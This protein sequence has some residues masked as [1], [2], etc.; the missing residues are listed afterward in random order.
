MSNLTM[1]ACYKQSSL[2]NASGGSALF[3]IYLWEIDCHEHYVA[4]WVCLPCS[5]YE[6]D[7]GDVTATQF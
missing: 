4:E 3:E 5:V 2:S 6:N 7:G 1:T